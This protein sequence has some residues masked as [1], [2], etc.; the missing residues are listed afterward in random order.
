M[1]ELR[2]HR[3]I[4]LEKSLDEA[5]QTYGRF[6][7]FERADEAAHFVL[8]LQ[9]KS[10]GRERQVAGELSNYVLGLTIRGRKTR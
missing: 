8:R 2:F 5:L 9:G 10:A 1:T 3:E 6:A 7:K 4:Y